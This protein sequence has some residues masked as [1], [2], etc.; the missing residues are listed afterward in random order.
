MCRRFPAQAGMNR[1][2]PGRWSCRARGAIEELAECVAVSMTV[3]HAPHLGLGNDRRRVLARPPFCAGSVSVYM[4]TLVSGDMWN[5][6][7]VRAV[8]HEALFPRA[9]ESACRRAV[10]SC[11]NTGRNVSTGE[12]AAD[13]MSSQCHCSPW[14][15]GGEGLAP[16]AIARNMP[17]DTAPDGQPG[18][19]GDELEGLAGPATLP[20]W[21]GQFMARRPPLRGGPGRRPGDR[22]LHSGAAAGLPVHRPSDAE[23]MSGSR[24]TPRSKSSMASSYRPSSAFASLRPK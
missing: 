6:G 1:H 2:E 11:C 5:S 16:L 15:P 13:F 3:E 17:V 19:A 20:W 24:W 4:E 8:A 7:F 23:A 14:S 12:D 10:P 18:V 9:R 21:K 22:A